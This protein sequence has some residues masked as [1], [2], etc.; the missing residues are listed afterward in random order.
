[1]PLLASVKNQCYPGV[2]STHERSFLQ[3]CRLLHCV[4]TSFVE[5]MS[6]TSSSAQEDST[7]QV[8]FIREKHRSAYGEYGWNMDAERR[9]CHA[10][11]DIATNQ[12]VA[13]QLQ[14]IPFALWISA[15]THTI[16]FFEHTNSDQCSHSI[17]LALVNHNMRRKGTLVLLSD[18]AIELH[19]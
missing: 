6:A 16:Y 10:W 4:R 19:I 15:N 13:M 12:G 3:Q 5:W 2:R 1:M 18:R 8:L 17:Q 11:P 7:V 14:G 9:S